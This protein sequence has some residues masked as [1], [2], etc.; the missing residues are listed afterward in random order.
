MAIG[1]SG[2]ILAKFSKCNSM[3]K[4][5]SNDIK[6]K[7]FELQVNLKSAKSPAEL[8]NSEMTR[9]IFSKVCGAVC[10]KKH[11]SKPEKSKSKRSFMQRNSY[12]SGKCDASAVRIREFSK[13][14]IEIGSLCVP[15]KS[16]KCACP[17]CLRRNN[18]NQQNDISKIG[19][20]ERNSKYKSDN[21]SQLKTN[22]NAIHSRYEDKTQNMNSSENS[23]QH[24]REETEELVEKRSSGFRNLLQSNEYNSKLQLNKSRSQ[25]NGVFSEAEVPK[26]LVLYE[27]KFK[28]NLGEK[29]KRDVFITMK[30]D[31]VMGNRL[32]RVLS[33]DST[34]LHNIQNFT[35][36]LDDQTCKT[37]SAE[38]FYKRCLNEDHP[39]K[40]LQKDN[41]TEHTQKLETIFQTNKNEHMTDGK[42]SMTNLSTEKSNSEISIQEPTIVSTSIYSLKLGK[43]RKKIPRGI[44]FDGKNDLY[45]A[46]KNQTYIL[47]KVYSENRFHGMYINMRNIENRTDFA[48]DTMIKN[49]S[50]I[51]ARS[52]QV[53]STNQLGN[54]IFIP[55]GIHSIFQSISTET[56]KLLKK[57]T[58]I[59]GHNILTENIEYTSIPRF[60]FV[61]TL[62]ISDHE[63]VPNTEYYLERTLGSLSVP[64]IPTRLEATPVSMLTTNIQQDY[65]VIYGVHS[66]N[67]N[68]LQNENFQKYRLEN[69]SINITVA[70][71]KDILDTN[72]HFDVDY[73]DTHN[74]DGELFVYNT[75][76]RPSNEC[77]NI[78]V[79]NNSQFRRSYSSIC[80]GKK[81]FENKTKC[82]ETCFMN[83]TKSLQDVIIHKDAEIF[84]L[85]RALAVSKICSP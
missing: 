4:A 3:K 17:C 82:E 56:L 59:S 8:D 77:S 28:T 11:I 18:S 39:S 74:K 10:A 26:L 37:L 22:I 32:S 27:N 58:V 46:V 30:Q 44:L 5:L 81:R 33:G 76:H 79:L 29:P 55:R 48:E 41:T 71:N 34:G 78:E 61:G 54:N 45:R 38:I 50:F 12:I 85:R 64:N 15:G 21:R 60:Q 25:T 69:D 47:K 31:T 80:V 49:F 43:Y 14:T 9:A 53:N 2:R 1:T 57:Q 65:S 6:N 13:N 16:Q 75:E 73:Y 23:Q 42:K 72:S 62:K 68:S 35:I 66:P 84:A 51:V 36:L 52:V 63:S 20:D 7:S 83:S 40:L 24:R 19:N 67:S 70:P